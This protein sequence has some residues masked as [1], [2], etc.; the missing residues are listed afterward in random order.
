MLENLRAR[1][2]RRLRR[3]KPVDEAPL[4]AALPRSVEE[5]ALPMPPADIRYRIVSQPLGEYDY[6]RVGIDG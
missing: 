6:L 5:S 4:I 3:P 1:I 2:A